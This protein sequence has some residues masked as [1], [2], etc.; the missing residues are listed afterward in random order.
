MCADRLGDWSRASSPW[1]V[2]ALVVSI[3]LAAAACGG[4]GGSGAS[5]PTVPPSTSQPPSNPPTTPSAPSNRSPLANDTNQVATFVQFHSSRFDPRPFFSDPDGDELTFTITF[6]FAGLDPQAPPGLRVE[7]GVLVGEPQVEGYYHA[8]ASAADPHGAITSLS[9]NFRVVPNSP[10]EV[11]SGNEDLITVVGASVDIETSKAGAV[12]ADADGDPLDYQVALRGEPRGLSVEG[13]RVRGTLSSVGLVEVTITASDGYGGTASDVFIVVGP[14]PEPGMPTL[15]ETHYVYE[16]AALALPFLFRDS[17]RDRALEDNRPTNA[18]ATLGRVLFYDKRL[19]STNTVACASC[20]QQAHGFTIPERFPTG[21]LGVPL[22]RNALGLSNVR[23]SSA[24]RWFWDMRAS[25]LQE[26]VLMPI[27]NPE[28]LGSPLEHLRTKLAAT[29]FYA[30]LFEAAFGTPEVTTERISKALAQF[31]QSLLSYE[32]RFNIAYTPMYN[33]AG[34]PEAVLT[35]EELRGAEIFNGE[36]Q[37]SRCHDGRMLTNDWWAN[38]GLDLVLT[39]LGIQI[40]MLQRDGSN[41]MFRAAALTNIAVTAPYMHDGR[42]STLREVIDHYDHGIQ[43]S[44]GLDGILRGSDGQP[45]RLNLSDED[46]SALEA[47]LNSTT[48]PAFLEDPRFSDPF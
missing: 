1:L 47:F 28:E 42:F 20:H 33:G 48:D 13:T 35:A 16:D 37:C 46:R 19:S 3:A 29:A 12:F 43:N 4:G 41:G 21:A 44:P 11:V 32:S 45:T 7:E 39:D 38:N 18:G 34:D 2:R 27:Q 26:L 30:P 24:G 25:S 10:P 40:P 17:F 14:G 15:P 6:G 9:F 8:M 23:F 31:L 36:G 5:H 22:R